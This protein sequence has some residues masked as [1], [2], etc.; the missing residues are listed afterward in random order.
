M[1]IINGLAEGVKMKINVQLPYDI[2]G[3]L[4]YILTAQD[5]DSLDG[6]IA[7]LTKLKENAVSAGYSNLTVC[8]NDTCYSLWGDREETPDEAFAK[9]EEGQKKREKEFW[10]E[11]VHK[12]EA[13]YEEWLKKQTDDK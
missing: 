3:D 11:K 4:G 10:D 13:H 7:A 5:T 8:V 1:P 2:G 6:I 12:A 9:T